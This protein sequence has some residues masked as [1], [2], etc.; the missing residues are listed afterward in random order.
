[1]LG[2]TDRARVKRQIARSSSLGNAVLIPFLRD[3]GDASGA[4]VTILTDCP[5]GEGVDEAKVWGNRRYGK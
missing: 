2:F 5:Y 1:M 4:L 3:R